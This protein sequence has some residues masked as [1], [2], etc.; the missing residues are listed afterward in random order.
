MVD[1][2]SRHP[3]LNLLNLEAAAAARA[4]DA[5]VW[6][7]PDAAEGILPGVLDAERIPWSVQNRKS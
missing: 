7:S 4:L 3:R 6:L 2:V 1:L 5:T